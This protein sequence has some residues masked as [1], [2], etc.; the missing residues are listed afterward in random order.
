M[1][2]YSGEVPTTQKRASLIHRTGKRK[3]PEAG[4][5][6]VP[7]QKNACGNCFSLACTCKCHG[8]QVGR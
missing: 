8:A 5:L 6:S 7:C 2:Q 1:I 3:T 4:K